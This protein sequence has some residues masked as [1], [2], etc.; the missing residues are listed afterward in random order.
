M[1]P[2]PP[3]LHPSLKKECSCSFW[4]QLLEVRRV[5]PD[6][7]HLSSSWKNGCKMKQGWGRK[8]CKHEAWARGRAREQR[9]DEAV[10]S[11]FRGRRLKFA[12]LSW[13]FAPSLGGE[14]VWYT[15]GETQ[16]CPSDSRPWFRY[17]L[18][19]SEFNSSLTCFGWWTGK[20]WR[21][22][23]QGRIKQNCHVTCSFHSAI[24]CL[25]PVWR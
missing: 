10:L 8:H 15:W 21:L 1:F 14:S 18:I 2:R 20:N 13:W 4:L 25:G 6:Y 16:T 22:S 3:F 19:P 24:L 23:P 9:G 11:G 7:S 12:V 5:F 17:F